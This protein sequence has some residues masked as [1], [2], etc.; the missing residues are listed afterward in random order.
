MIISKIVCRANNLNKLLFLRNHTF[1]KIELA[2]HSSFR[3]IEQS[4]DKHTQEHAGLYYTIPT[5]IKKQIFTYGGL[6]KSF[7]KQIKTFAETSLMIRE[8]AI[9]IINYI[10][11]TDLSKPVNRF[12]LYGKD[13]VGKSLI[14][15]HVLHYGFESEYVLVHIPWTAN[16]FKKPK[17]LGPSPSHEGQ[18]DLPLDAAAWLIHFKNS[19]QDLLQKLKLTTSQDYIWSKREKTEANSPLIELIEHG[20]TRVKFACDTVSALLHELKVHSSAGNCKT[21]VAIDGVNSFF[22]H[23]TRIYGDNKVVIT[24]EKLSLTKAFLNI[25]NWNWT[26]GVVIATVDRIAMTDNYMESE[27]PLYLLGKKGFEH[28]DPFIPIHVDNFTEKEFTRC[29]E[30]Y[31]ER[32][33]IQNNKPGFSDELKFLSGKNPYKLMN[34]CASL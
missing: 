33:W 14:L 11:Q 12:I 25:T 31:I 17:E 19:N 20:I 28:F 3:T 27:Y 23:E 16:W 10:K 4:P 7:E 15:A 22:H 21:M 13:G 32:K 8:P 9:E 2:S 18:Y 29:I 34:I 5:N 6:P 30:Y 1:A 24:P 26:N